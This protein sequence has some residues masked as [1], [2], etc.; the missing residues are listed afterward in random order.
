[1]YA[2]QSTLYEGRMS[3]NQNKPN[4]AMVIEII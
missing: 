3:T 1:M 2:D 4:I